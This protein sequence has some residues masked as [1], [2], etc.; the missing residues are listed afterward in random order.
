MLSQVNK[1]AGQ[2]Y[3][4]QVRSLLCTCTHN[5]L[6]YCWPAL[7][8]FITYVTVEGGSKPEPGL[9]GRLCP[10][11]AHSRVGL[12]WYELEMSECSRDFVAGGDRKGSRL[13]EM[14]PF[15]SSVTVDS[16]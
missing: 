10:P 2:Q 9:R 8:L 3:Q 15:V 14:R 11:N 1:G 13:Y 5:S 6:S 12:R 4:C 16:A 7:L